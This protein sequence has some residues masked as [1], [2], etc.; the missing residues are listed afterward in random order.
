MGQEVR[1]LRNNMQKEISVAKIRMLR[2]MNTT[3]LT[4]GRYASI[5]A[6]IPIFY[7][8]L[9]DKCKILSDIILDRYRA[10]YCPV[11]D[12]SADI[13]DEYI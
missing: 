7:Q 1:Q 5:S 3:V 9:Y 13:R 8:K 10:T 6:K 11:D 2:W 4:L 12:I